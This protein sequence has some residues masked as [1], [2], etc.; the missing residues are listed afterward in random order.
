MFRDSAKAPLGKA[1]MR[2]LKTEVKP[3]FHILTHFRPIFVSHDLK[4]FLK[5]P[6][7]H[8]EQKFEE[9]TFSNVISGSKL[10]HT[11]AILVHAEAEKT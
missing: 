1:E 9:K 4:Q 3:F 6:D 11:F 8:L 7:T 2:R 5:A 10:K